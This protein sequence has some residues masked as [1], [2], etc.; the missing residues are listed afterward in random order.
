M[1]K[2]W[3]RRKVA[4]DIT[5]TDSGFH[6]HQRQ[7][8][9]PHAI[10]PPGL[11]LKPLFTMKTVNTVECVADTLTLIWYLTLILLSFLLF[12][13][14]KKLLGLFD[15]TCS[16]PFNFISLEKISLL[17][18][19]FFDSCQVVLVFL[20]FDF[21]FFFLSLFSILSSSLL[22]VIRERVIRESLA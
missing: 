18:F 11:G 16:F 21:L 22:F 20:S 7:R 13:F 1:G 4:R 2:R 5:N 10:Q 14:V 8:R 19:V 6:L 3:Q 12:L 15:L 17:C 9:G